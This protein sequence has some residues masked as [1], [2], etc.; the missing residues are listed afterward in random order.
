LNITLTAEEAV[1]SVFMHE[2]EKDL[3]DRD[4]IKKFGHNIIHDQNQTILV[5]LFLG[6][7]VAFKIT[8]LGSSGAVPAYGRL[9]S[10]Q[11]LE[12]QNHYFLIDC[13]EGR[14]DSTHEV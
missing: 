3:K 5:I 10:C 7:I 9:P 8:I 2:I 11:F 4:T 12:I 13:G 6:T 14:P 1:D